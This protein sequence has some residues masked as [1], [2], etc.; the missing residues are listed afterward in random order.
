MR[1]KNRIAKLAADMVPIFADPQRAYCYLSRVQR[2]R[3]IAG[4][5]RFSVLT[6]DGEEM[7]FEVRFVSPHV[8]RVRCYRP[9]EEPP[10]DSAMLVDGGLRHESVHVEAREGRVVIRSD[11]LELRVVRRPFHYGVF[12]LKGRK[13]LVQQIGD[14]TDS[15]LVSLPLG[16]SRDL[17]GRI[18]FHESFE[19][20]PDERLDSTEHGTSDLR[21]RRIVLRP[22][23]A[24]GARAARSGPFFIWSSAGYGVFVHHGGETVY[25]L[26]CPSSITCSFRVEDAYLDYSIVFGADAEEIAAR[27]VG[28]CDRGAA[29]R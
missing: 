3:R 13:L 22:G 15:R 27:Y 4:G 28:I 8:V 29:S 2:Y 21:G 26:G 11:A 7:T 23:G 6:N 14:V 18:A 16:C 12:D 10:T 25:E 19:L 5:A 1:A 9:G 17:R 24:R 20:A